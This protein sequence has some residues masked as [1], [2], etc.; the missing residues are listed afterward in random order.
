MAVS[1]LTALVAAL[2]AAVGLV[3][4]WG[5]NA[6]QIGAHD[7]GLALFLAGLSA[8]L[9][10]GSTYAIPVLVVLGL[11]SFLVD[12]RSALYFLIAAIVCGVPLAILSLFA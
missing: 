11:M 10:V 3:A 6:E 5:V 4:H 1:R 12:R 2:A 8:V 9:L 7:A